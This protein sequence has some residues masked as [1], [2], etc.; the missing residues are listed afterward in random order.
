MNQASHRVTV[1]RADVL[2]AVAVRS[3]GMFD[4]VIANP[5]YFDAGRHSPPSSLIRR[6]ARQHDPEALSGWLQ[7]ANRV[8]KPKGTITLIHSAE[9]LD[10]LVTGLKRF[11]GA[12]TVFPFWPRPDRACKRLV[13]RAT[14]GSR[15]PL[16][17]LPGLVIHGEDGLSTQRALDIINHGHSLW[18]QD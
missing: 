6:L 1:H 14:K 16:A 8:L 13:V 11:C 10:E 9:K 7:A 4:H 12:I 15:A 17:L 5:P 3:L 18:E 2:N